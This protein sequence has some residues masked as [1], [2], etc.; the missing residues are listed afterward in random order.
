MTNRRIIELVVD[1]HVS[2][3]F[4]KRW[5]RVNTIKKDEYIWEELEKIL[6]SSLEILN[7]VFP[8]QEGGPV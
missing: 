7:S 4:A 5:L 2:A 1:M 3:D 8:E 6:S